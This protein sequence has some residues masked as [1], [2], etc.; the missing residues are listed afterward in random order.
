LPPGP[1]VIPVKAATFLN[2]DGKHA[3]FQLAPELG[4]FPHHGAGFVFADLDRG[5]ARRA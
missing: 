1:A 4:V 2:V 5:R 3:D